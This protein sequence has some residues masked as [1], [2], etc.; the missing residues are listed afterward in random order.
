MEYWS[1]I[2]DLIRHTVI[3]FK[4]LFTHVM[5]YVMLFLVYILS[6]FGDKVQLFNYILVCMIIDLIWGILSNISKGTFGFSKCFVRTA[7]KMAIY[8]SLFTMCV[9]LEQVMYQ[10]ISVLTR[11]ISTV[12]CSGEFISI[13]AHILIVK[14]NMPILKLLAKYLTKEIAKKLSVNEAEV[15]ELLTNK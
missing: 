9:L 2:C 14:P 3:T 6:T 1:L 5:G 8:I 10:K 7:I 11:T 13:I 12:L 4:E 15:I